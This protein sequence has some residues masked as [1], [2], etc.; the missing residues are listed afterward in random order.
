MAEKKPVAAKK[1]KPSAFDQPVT[2]SADLAEIVGKG[3]M[4]RTKITKELW[5][6]IKKNKCQNPKN[7]REIIPDAKLSKVLG[8]KP[9]DMFQMTR[10]VSKHVEAKVKA[11]A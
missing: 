2:P 8:N 11:K 1:R 6:Y 10:L 7:K 4:P 9:V 5:D 3:P